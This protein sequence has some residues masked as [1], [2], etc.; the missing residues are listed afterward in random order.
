MTRAGTGLATFNG[1][2][3]ESSLLNDL[4]IILD[5]ESMTWDRLDAAY[6][7]F[8]CLGRQLTF[9][10]FS[11]SPPPEEFAGAVQFLLCAPTCHS[12]VF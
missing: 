2:D 1:Q 5:P 4:H 6:A 9:Y 12:K 11:R 3:A 8:C 10:M 7:S